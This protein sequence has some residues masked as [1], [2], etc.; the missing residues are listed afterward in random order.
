MKRHRAVF[1]QVYT[2]TE[3]QEKIRGDSIK[4]TMFQN[5]FSLILSSYLP[6]SSIQFTVKHKKLLMWG[7]PLLIAG[8]FYNNYNSHI[9]CFSCFLQCRSCSN[10]RTSFLS[11]LLTP[12]HLFA[13]K[14][15]VA[16]RCSVSKPCFSNLHFFAIFDL[17]INKFQVGSRICF[18]KIYS[19]TGYY[20]VE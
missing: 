5:K 20:G 1:R 10:N 12:I 15:Q 16:E 2:Y 6:K 4:F 13:A 8:E 9:F 14:D 3:L 7:N 11:T 18:F 19:Q 17:K